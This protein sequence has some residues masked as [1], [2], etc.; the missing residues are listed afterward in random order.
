[1]KVLALAA[2]AALLS[3]APASSQA[4]TSTPPPVVFTTV[5]AVKVDHMQLVITGVVQ[6]EA[7]PSDRAFYF[8]FSVGSTYSAPYEQRQSCE[9][10]ALLAMA[11]P[12]QYL[13]E[14]QPAAYGNYTKCKLSRATP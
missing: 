6:G 8:D 7:A 10:L 3:A 14:V 12:G 1:M 9:R 5:D 13:L 4:Q 11:K 2:A